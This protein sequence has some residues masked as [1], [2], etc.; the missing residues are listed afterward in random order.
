MAHNSKGNMQQ[1]LNKRVAEQRTLLQENKGQP[2]AL[3]ALILVRQQPLALCTDG[4]ASQQ[5][6]TLLEAF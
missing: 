3:G 6:M 1:H 5:Q 4:L 2:L